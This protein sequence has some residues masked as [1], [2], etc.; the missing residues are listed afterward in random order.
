MT[1]DLHVNISHSC[2]L[3]GVA[4]LITVKV[5]VPAACDA[6]SRRRAATAFPSAYYPYIQPP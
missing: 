6:G 2:T 1:F 4:E 5:G 3:A